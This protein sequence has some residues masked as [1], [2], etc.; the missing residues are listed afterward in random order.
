MAKLCLL[1]AACSLLLSMVWAP[2]KW[3][4]LNINLQI[5]HWLGKDLVRGPCLTVISG[6]SLEFLRNP[7]ISPTWTQRNSYLL[8]DSKTKEKVPGVHCFTHMLLS[9]VSVSFDWSSHQGLKGGGHGRL[10]WNENV[11]KYRKSLEAAGIP[12]EIEFVFVK[13]KPS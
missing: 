12:E 1:R 13:T 4:L 3:R 9:S 5:Q 8:I 2:S 7:R 11:W 6:I 10:R